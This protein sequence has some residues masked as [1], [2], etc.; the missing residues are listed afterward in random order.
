MAANAMQLPADIAERYRVLSSLRQS[1]SQPRPTVSK[2]RIAEIAVLPSPVIMTAAMGVLKST[3]TTSVSSV[4]Q[5]SASKRRS[6]PCD[7][8]SSPENVRSEYSH[9]EELSRLAVDK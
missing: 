7:T 9:V 8:G 4:I 3:T 6:G 5:Q 2:P 1:S